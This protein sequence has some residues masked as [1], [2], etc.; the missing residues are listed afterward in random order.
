MKRLLISTAILV[1]T[2]VAGVADTRKLVIAQASEGMIY[3]PI[4]VARGMGYFAEEGIDAEVIVLHGGSPATAAL[5]SGDA[6]VQIGD[7]T[8]AITA[9]EKGASLKI[10]GGALQQFGTNLVIRASLADELGITADSPV[11]D[12]IRALKGLNIGITAPGGTP[13]KQVRYMLNSVGLDPDRDATLVPLGSAGP[14]LA[15]FSQGRI[16]AFLLSPPTTN[17]AILK[18]GARMLVDMSVGEFEPFRGFPQLTLVARRDWLEENPDLAVA[19]VK[20]VGRAEQ[21]I[22]EDPAAAGEAMRQFFPDLE[23]EVYDAA[24]MS[25]V[26]SFAKTPRIDEGT[27]EKA[28]EFLAESGVTVTTPIS[29]MY[30]NEYVEQAGF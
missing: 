21:L 23:K 4:Y 30:T 27:L 15:A 5:V 6:D 19:Y 10:I 11:E 26:K 7:P 16:D 17:I 29:D 3:T 1:A 8:T 20:A 24:F 2:T 9:H 25:N 13:D 12:K 28:Y 14:L 22:A 18:N